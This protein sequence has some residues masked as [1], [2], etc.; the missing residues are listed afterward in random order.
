MRVSQRLDYALRLV[1]LLAMH[2]AEEYV[3]A[4]E[5][6]DSLGLPRRFAEQQVSVLARAGVVRCR[7]G[8]TGGC[9]LARPPDEISVRDVVLGLEGDVIDVPHQSGSASA[10]LWGHAA[11]TLSAYLGSVTLE[12]LAARQLELDATSTAMY[13][14]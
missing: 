12:G 4:G 5:L 8:A 7:R 6:A 1:V 10:E 3:A 2:P 14:I 13:Y 9:T 11:A